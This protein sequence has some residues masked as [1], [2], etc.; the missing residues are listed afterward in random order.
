MYSHLFLRGILWW[1]SSSGLWHLH[2][3]ITYHSAMRRSVSKS[4]DKEYPLPHLRRPN[5]HE[6][7]R[8]K[9]GTCKSNSLFQQIQCTS[10]I[11]PINDCNSCLDPFGDLYAF[12]FWCTCPQIS[13]NFACVGSVFSFL[14]GFA[15]KTGLSSF[16][17]YWFNPNLYYTL[18]VNWTHVIYNIF[19]DFIAP[20]TSI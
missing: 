17:A 6:G 19:S 14:Y 7:Y 13:P 16:E 15:L 11:R 8:P 2:W 1:C 12:H 18:F 4:M 9:Y 3:P 5:Q 10:G 20:G